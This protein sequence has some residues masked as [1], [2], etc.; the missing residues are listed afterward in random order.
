MYP[1]NYVEIY[2]H[3]VKDIKKETPFLEVAI[4]ER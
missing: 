4:Y 1:L 2:F 3:F